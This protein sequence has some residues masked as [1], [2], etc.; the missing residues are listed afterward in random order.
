LGQDYLNHYSGLS[1]FAEYAVVSR[2]SL[3]RIEEDIPLE[4]AAV[5]G[6]AV[7]TG[8]GPS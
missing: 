4:D 1:V 7:I 3:V 8:V 6:C 5:F 2:N